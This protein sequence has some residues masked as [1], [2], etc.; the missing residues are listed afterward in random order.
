M[1]LSSV[2]SLASRLSP[3][4]PIF[5]K[6][7]RTTSRRKRNYFLRV[8]YLGALLLFLLAV[9]AG[10]SSSYGGA[11]MRA[12][13]QAQLGEAFFICFTMFSVLAMALIAPVVTSTAI[14]GERM[15]KTYHVLLMTPITSWQIVSGKLLSR[16]LT[17]FTLLGL[18]LP[19]LALVRLLGGVELSQ[20]FGVVCIAVSLA[21]FMA[22]LG[23]LLSIM[24]N[25]AY[26][27]ILFCYGAALFLY[28]FVPF[29]VG[30]TMSALGPAGMGGRVA[31]MQ[32][33]GNTNPIFCAG[34]LA[35]GEINRMG[36]SW[37]ICVVV[38]LAASAVLVLLCGVMLRRLARRE[39][40]GGAAVGT[41]APV[42][43]APMVPLPLPALPG[44]LKED[45][46]FTAGD[47]TRPASGAAKKDLAISQSLPATLPAPLPYA[48]PAPVQQRTVSDHP[49][50]WR[51]CRRPLMTRMW[52][53]VAG[54]IGSVGLLGLT[55]L[56]MAAN[57]WL[58][59]DEIQIGYAFVF[60]G[61][62]ML[63]ATVIAATAIAQE[64]ESDTWT[65][66]LVSP[67]S[68]TSIVMGKLLGVLRR[69][70][71]P[72]ILFAA[73]FLIFTIGGVIDFDTFVLIV[74]VMVMYNLLFV[75]TGVYLSLRIP[76]VTF[77][78]VVNL[79]I[80]IVMYVAVPVI[81]VIIG[82]LIDEH[83]LAEQVLWYLPFYWL[84]EG[85]SSQDSNTMRLEMMRGV[86]IDATTFFML[87]FG[88]G[89]VHVTAAA[90]IVRHTIARFDR[91][92]GR[93]LQHKAFGAFPVR[94]LARL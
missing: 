53:R 30:T 2:L 85:I 54:V 36:V 83:R 84:G 20:M 65:V 75:A 33:I 57:D 34:L 91:I 17:A 63:L 12:Q 16:L 86:S 3:F 89:L 61:L 21:I 60:H 18:S 74:G 23:L 52:Q 1:A 39:G 47:E 90:L 24:I 73:H 7:L 76:K 45:A 26:A 42:T 46:G 31:W 58:D 35:T 6:E 68:G 14:S 78:V 28:G 77:A 9:H 8:I 49:V 29:V 82:E 64:K 66:L 62:L 11:A 67:L 51:E 80:P 22:A 40:E 71:W 25:R 19:V 50:L 55:Y 5:T 41:P 48:S 69:L 81:L 79:A 37:W 4:G 70:M 15:Q 32:W 27:V 88:I 13:Q 59:D 72:L 87:V 94:H 56:L 44:A 92:V 43:S 38:H 10:S 93:A